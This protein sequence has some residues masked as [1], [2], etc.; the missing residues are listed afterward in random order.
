MDGSCGCGRISDEENI[1]ILNFLNPES[2]RMVKE[3]R[4]L[5]SGLNLLKSVWYVFL[6]NCEPPR[7]GIRALSACT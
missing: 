6:R 7:A 2:G 4:E 5:T 3:V 1:E